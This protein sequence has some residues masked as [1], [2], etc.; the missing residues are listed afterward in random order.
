MENLLI[1]PVLF[2][3]TSWY[4]SLGSHEKLVLY[5]GKGR[6]SL[7]NSSPGKHRTS[8]SFLSSLQKRDSEEPTVN[9]T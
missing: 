5:V 8:P 4:W 2:A 3:G 1:A 6:K 9:A 7:E